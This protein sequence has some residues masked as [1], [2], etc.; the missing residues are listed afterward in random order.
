VTEVTP[1]AFLQCLTVAAIGGWHHTSLKYLQRQHVCFT[2]VLRAG[3]DFNRVASAMGNK[4][5]AA[6]L[7]E[8]RS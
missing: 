2:A 7:G 3:E 5:E 6:R 1:G 8:Q 4:P